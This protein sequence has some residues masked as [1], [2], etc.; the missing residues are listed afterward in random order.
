M[1]GRIYSV[2]ILRSEITVTI[3]S[4]IILSL[5]LK[6]PLVGKLLSVFHLNECVLVPQRFIGNGIIQCHGAGQS[7]LGVIVVTLYLQV[8]AVGKCVIQIAFAVP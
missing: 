7:S 6:V 5:S 2:G 8:A 1:C 3:P 4:V